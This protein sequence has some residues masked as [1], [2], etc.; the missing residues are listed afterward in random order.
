MR[1]KNAMNLALQVTNTFKDGIWYNPLSL[2]SEDDYE[3][4]HPSILKVNQVYIDGP[5]QLPLMY[6]D[7]NSIQLGEDS[8]EEVKSEESTESKIDTTEDS[9]TIKDNILKSIS[10]T[11]SLQGNNISTEKIK[12]LVSKI[13]DKNPEITLENAIDKLNKEVANGRY[14]PSI[15]KVGDKIVASEIISFRIDGDQVK[16]VQKDNSAFTDT[17]TQYLEKKGISNSA[18]ISDYDRGVIY[19]LDNSSGELKVK[20]FKVNLKNDSFS[21]VDTGSI[22]NEFLEYIK[23][24]IEEIK[25]SEITP[26]IKK[27]ELKVPYPEFKNKFLDITESINKKTLVGKA[28]QKASEN[29]ITFGEIVSRFYSSFGS[30]KV[31]I[32]STDKSDIINALKEDKS[33]QSLVSE[34]TAQLNE[35]ITNSRIGGQ[36]KESMV[37]SLLVSKFIDIYY[38]EL[39]CI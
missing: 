33:I 15:L 9:L 27:E 14:Y 19:T 10:E 4:Y 32:T 37:S 23:K 20:M 6:I 29:T 31:K 17:I 3:G 11:I 8:S 12:N 25:S 21:L 7:Y 38:N 30:T 26:I 36:L 28:L 18:S 16:L 2:G 34:V 24:D 1:N 13:F 35:V 39:K 5:I 22:P